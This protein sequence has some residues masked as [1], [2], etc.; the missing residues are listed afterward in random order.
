MFTKFEVDIAYSAYV[1]AQSFSNYKE[2]VLKGTIII[3]SFL[4][5]GGKAFIDGGAFSSDDVIFQ[6]FVKELGTDF[7]SKNSKFRI[8]RIVGKNNYLLIERLN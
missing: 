3:S 1:I 5:V 6:N 8:S 2:N 7:N 4:K